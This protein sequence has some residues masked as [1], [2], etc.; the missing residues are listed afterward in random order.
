L[1]MHGF[2]EAEVSQK[3]SGL[4]AFLSMLSLEG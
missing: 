4:Q 2:E 1:V 3:V